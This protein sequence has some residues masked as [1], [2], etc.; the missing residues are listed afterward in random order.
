MAEQAIIINGTAH[1]FGSLEIDVDGKFLAVN[2]TS[3]DYSDNLEGEDVFGA[4]AQRIARTRG[5]YKAEG[6]IKLTKR[7]AQ[8]VIDALAP[9]GGIYDRVFGLRVTYRDTDGGGVICDEL[10][11]VRITGQANSHS[12]G[13]SALEG[14]C[15]LNIGIILW[16]GVAPIDNAVS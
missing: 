15:P 7:G 2:C 16:N 8:T 5:Q 1:D 13:A 3:I 14:D 11:G 6:S 12:A 9:Q 4:S 10:R